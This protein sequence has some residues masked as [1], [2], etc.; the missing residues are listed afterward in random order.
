M[1]KPIISKVDMDKS[2]Q[3]EVITMAN[4]AYADMQNHKSVAQ[5]MKQAMDQKHGPAWHCISGRD[6]NSFVAY[7]RKK[8][9]E[10]SIAGYEYLLYKCGQ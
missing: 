5:Y 1:T 3:E 2:M 10:F 6:F 4:N 9:I 8:F 7:E